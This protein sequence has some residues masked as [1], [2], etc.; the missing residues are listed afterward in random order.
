VEE[1]I[2]EVDFE[3]VD[4]MLTFDPEETN[5]ND[6]LT[7]VQYELPPHYKCAAHTLNLI[8]SKDV[9]KYLSSSSTSKSVYHSSFAKSSALWNKVN[10]STLASDIVQ[11][12]AKRKLV[13]PTATRWNSF[14]DAVVRITENSMAE[15]SELCTKMKLRC[16]NERELNFLKEYCIV[17]KPLSRSLDIL[18]G[19]DNCYFGTLLPTLETVIKK[20][21][22]IS[23]P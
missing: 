6:H 16:F 5:I 8:A 21:V 18:Q 20:L 14:Y 13:V 23:L 3:N 10:R 19:E 22:A 7:Q 11:E 15:L 2:E 17:L 9:D 12:V 4:E 1:E